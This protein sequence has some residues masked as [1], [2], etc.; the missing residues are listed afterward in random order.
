M[1]FTFAISVND[2][3]LGEL[4]E[5]AFHQIGERHYSVGPPGSGI[6][7]EMQIVFPAG[8]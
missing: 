6:E 5:N 3:A 8:A 7:H 4:R 1:R 2:R